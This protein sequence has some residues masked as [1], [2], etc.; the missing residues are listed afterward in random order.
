MINIYYIHSHNG[1]PPIKII[2]TPGFGDTGGLAKD[3]L[4]S[5]KIAEK[6]QQE[7]DHINAICFVAQSTNSKLTI[8][9]KY[10][11]NSI[12]NLRLHWWLYKVSSWL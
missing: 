5:E 11:F 7:V 10:I 3:K 8:N 2:D 9:Q 4:I 12:Y 1:H 6:F